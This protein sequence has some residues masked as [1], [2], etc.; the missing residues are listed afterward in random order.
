MRPTELRYTKTHEWV[1]VEDKEAVF[2]ITDYAVEHLSD[3]TFIELPDIGDDIRKGEGFG[4]IE[5]VKAVA[6]LNAPLSGTVKEV[7]TDIQDNLET[8]S[9]DPFGK[10]WLIRIEMSD[11]G[12]VKSLLS[13]AEYE[14]IV[15][16][17]AE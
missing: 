6:E 7:N 14:K 8:L 16:A 2:G 15:E 11:P 4:E 17:E 9:E 12:E 5:S 3:L 1:R 13:G 10:G